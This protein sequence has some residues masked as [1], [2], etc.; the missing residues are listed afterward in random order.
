MRS[1]SAYRTEEGKPWVLPVVREAEKRL[2]DDMG[3]EYLPVLG[4]EPF[5]NAAVELVL[6]KNSPTIKAGKVC[7]LRI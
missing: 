3:H 7:N 6:G 5:C 2:A 1:F 4:Y